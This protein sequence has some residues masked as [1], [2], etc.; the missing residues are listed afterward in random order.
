MCRQ[1][2]VNYLW[3]KGEIVVVVGFC[4]EKRTSERFAQIGIHTLVSRGQWSVVRCIR[5]TNISELTTD[6]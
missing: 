6:N 4:C 2:G 3:I 5:T 1:R